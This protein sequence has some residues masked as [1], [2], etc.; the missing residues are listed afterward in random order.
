MNEYDVINTIEEKLVNFDRNDYLDFFVNCVDAEHIEI[1][2]QEELEDAGFPPETRNAEVKFKV[3]VKVRA[4]SKIIES[5]LEHDSSVLSEAKNEADINAYVDRIIENELFYGVLNTFI[6]SN[7][8]EFDIEILEEPSKKYGRDI[9]IEKLSDKM[10]SDFYYDEVVEKL[11]ELK[12]SYIE[13]L[14]TE[15]LKETGVLSDIPSLKPSDVPDDCFEA[16]KPE[17][18]CTVEDIADIVYDR[19]FGINSIFPTTE[20]FIKKVQDEGYHYNVMIELVPDKVSVEFYVKEDRLAEFL[21]E[22]SI[23]LH[24]L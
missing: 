7:I 16:Y 9:V 23:E 20:E 21:K 17:F 5:L 19:Y 18:N 1:L 8:V 2:K 4:W 10:E 14:K 12:P 22:G 15:A 24:E 6:E 3:N 13:E 11:R